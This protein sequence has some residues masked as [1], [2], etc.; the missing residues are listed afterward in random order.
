MSQILAS[1]FSTRLGARLWLQTAQCSHRKQAGG[2]L[3]L[4]ME[5]RAQAEVE[6]GASERRLHLKGQGGPP[7]A[8]ECQPVLHELDPQG[9]VG[10]RPGRCA[11]G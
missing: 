8:S 6:A 2:Y 4:Q 5:Q 9:E 11:L 10:D 7:G 1:R 3:S